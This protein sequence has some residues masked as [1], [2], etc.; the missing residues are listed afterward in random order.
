MH[1]I[2]LSISKGKFLYKY[3]PVHYSPLGHTKSNGPAKRL[4]WACWD[5]PR[6]HTTTDGVFIYLFILGLMTLSAT[7]TEQ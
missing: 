2:A 7:Q 5:D 6:E 4:L 1:Y 3:P